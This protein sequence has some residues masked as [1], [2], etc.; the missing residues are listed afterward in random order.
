MKTSALYN[1]TELHPLVFL[2]VKEQMGSSGFSHLLRDIYKP[3][4]KV[5]Y[6]TANTLSENILLAK[7][8]YLKPAV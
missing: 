3:F 7:H 4:H 8:D 2:R 6:T 5:Q 1:Q